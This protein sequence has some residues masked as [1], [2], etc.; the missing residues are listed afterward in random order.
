LRPARQRARLPRH[1]T[2]LDPVCVGA[3]RLRGRRG[4]L[5]RTRLQ[6]RVRQRQRVGDDDPDDRHGS[7]RGPDRI[8]GHHDRHRTAATS[9]P[10]PATSDPSTT[11][12]ADDTT[13]F[14]TNP[15]GA[16]NG[17]EC[18]ADL[19]C[20]TG[21]CYKIPL[22]LDDLPPG[23]CSECNT[24]Q[25]CVDRGL[26]ISCTVDPATL[27][28][29]C[30]D[31]GL[32]SFCATQAAC[33]PQYYCDEILNNA[34]GLLPHACGECRDDQDCKDGKR[35]TPRIDLDQYTGNKYC[36]A[37]GSV[38][39]DGLCPE[40]TGDGVCANGHCGV[41]NVVGTVN[42]GICGQCSADADC[43]APK[44]CMPG[45]FSDGIFGATCV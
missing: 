18:T 28:G 9:L 34:D 17:L 20:Q 38:P 32:G 37:P 24:D 30:T 40:F 36:A 27:G 23:I 26:G 42:V 45:T 13:G 19:E 5:D 15:D 1:A 7:H 41:I 6:R 43:A 33:K 25:D 22:P 3:D 14:E 11:S 2:P 8:P 21:H 35:C 12:T 16:A 31:G 4:H 44:V 39:N 29:H 10:D